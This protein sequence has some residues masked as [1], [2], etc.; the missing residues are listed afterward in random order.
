MCV[1]MGVDAMKGKV[2]NFKTRTS[3]GIAVTLDKQ[4]CSLMQSTSKKPREVSIHA[5]PQALR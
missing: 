4:S 5:N 1:W 2:S 3:F